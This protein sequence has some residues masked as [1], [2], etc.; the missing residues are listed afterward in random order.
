MLVTFEVMRFFFTV[1]SILLSTLLLAQGSLIKGMVKNKSTNEPIFSA[2]VILSN[3]VNGEMITGTTTNFE[4]LFQIQSDSYPISITVSYLGKED[5]KYLTEAPNETL[6]F[7]VAT[8]ILE[9][10][11]IVEER[12]QMT[13][14][15]G[16]K[17]FNVGSDLSN[18]GATAA[19]V[20]SN[21]PAV[22]LDVEGNVSLRGAQGVRI[23]INGKPSGMMGISSS[24]ALQFFPA[25]Q[26]QRVEVITNP[27]AKYEAQGAGGIINII[28]KDQ[29]KTGFNG[30][31]TLDAGIPENH[32]ISANLNFRRKWYNLFTNF[33][34]NTRRF[35]GG[36]FTEQTF[37]Y[38]DTS[39]SLRTDRE[40]DR[41]SLS[42]SV[43]F[44]SDFFLSKITTLK[45]S[46]VYSSG[47]ENNYTNLL[48][49]DY[50]A[51][52]FLPNFLSAQSKRRE[53]EEETEGNAEINLNFEHKFSE[54]DHQLT[55]DLQARRSLEIEDA[56]LYEISDL[57][58]SPK[59]TGLF[60]HSINQSVV[61]AYLSKLDYVYPFG[62]NGKFETGFRGEIREIE[63]L[64]LVEQRISE[65]LPFQELSEFSNTF[66]YTEEIAGVYT[67]L[68][69]SYGKWD[70]QAG[71]RL[72]F[73]GITTDLKTENSPQ[74]RSYL[75]FFPSFS[76]AYQF[77]ELNSIQASYSR[78]LDRPRFR[79]LNPYNTFV[80]ARSFNTGN[81][82]LDPEFSGTYDLGFIRYFEGAES[83]LY[84][85]LSYRNTVNDIVRVYTVDD[86][87]ITTRTPF[88]LARRE[89]IGI[90]GRFAYEFNDW[91]DANISS[92][93]FKGSTFGEANGES[94]NASSITMNAQG[95]M[96]FKVKKLADIQLSGNYEAP[97][98]QGQNETLARYAINFGARRKF[99]D[100]K[101]NIALSIRD[102]FNTR[103]YRSYSTGSNFNSY[104]EYQWRRG[105]FYNVSVS[106]RFN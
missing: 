65:L 100:D 74:Y 48:F 70:Y 88:N 37:R 29:K 43:R 92:F 106:Y 9:D 3:P 45:V 66:F 75:N 34:L 16:K 4:G 17:V 49:S 77:S 30:S 67:M 6:E 21:I 26:I 103:I 15:G 5:S 44:G 42:P 27:S 59:D 90:E 13:M 87:G 58:N 40:N 8:S 94:L 69:N 19:D 60:Q 57:L 33:N 22:S 54:K 93:V 83:S 47:D 7:L 63:N 89:N 32:G 11:V 78:R 104:R 53:L 102:L 101:L 51:E 36:G 79:E 72:E 82:E 105:P 64:F 18:S 71:L 39:F 35:P 31:V 84:M 25:N 46:G 50:S 20:L 1:L 97:Q 12:S 14:E 73:T 91:W 41:S 96:N 55:I 99:L 95:N 81:P 98:A 38:A 61:L 2:S 68:S 23:L 24:E 28:L 85:G 10:V 56:S 86:E 80:N 52:N 76:L 62:E